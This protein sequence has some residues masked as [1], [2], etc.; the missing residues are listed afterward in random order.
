MVDQ[1]QGLMRVYLCVCAR[2]FVCV[3]ARVR[4]CVYVCVYRG[5]PTAKANLEKL[6]KSKQR[7]ALTC[8]TIKE[9]GRRGQGSVL[10]IPMSKQM[11]EATDMEAGR[12]SQPTK[13]ILTII[14]NLLNS[15]AI[16]KC[17]RRVRGSRASKAADS[18]GS[19]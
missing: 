6:N 9:K 15:V 12:P 2:V 13:E 4:T 18:V 16:L 17:H 14:R 11:D 1:G 19:G 5:W 7:V 10:T 3:L 8:S